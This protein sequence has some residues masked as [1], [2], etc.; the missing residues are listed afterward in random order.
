MLCCNNNSSPSYLSKNWLPSEKLMVFQRKGWVLEH[1]ERL[2]CFGF[3]LSH[4][5][6]NKQ[7]RRWQ[8]TIKVHANR[9]ILL[10]VKLPNIHTKHW[11][12]NGASCQCLYLH[13][14]W[15]I[16]VPVC[17]CCDMPPVMIPAWWYIIW[18]F[19]QRLYISSLLFCYMQVDENRGSLTCCDS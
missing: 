6:I 17:F 9:S 18:K 15:R 7:T 1:A 5:T 8:Q 13:Q 2:L 11:S 10:F 12:S 4:C 14:A 16:H 3:R 19:G